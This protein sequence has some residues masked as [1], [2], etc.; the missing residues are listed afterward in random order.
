[1]IRVKIRKEEEGSLGGFM[2]E[3]MD[4]C[5][6]ALLDKKWSGSR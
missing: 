3:I 4:G 1:M 2:H 5:F 6:I